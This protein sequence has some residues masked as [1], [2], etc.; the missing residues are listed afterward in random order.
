MKKIF[1]GCGSIF[2]VF[3]L[4]GACV[5]VIGGGSDDTNNT[6]SAHSGKEDQKSVA[7]IGDKVEADKLAYQVESVEEK[8]EL[9]NALGT[10]RPGSGKF[11][12]VEVTV[13]NN[14]TEGRAVTESMTKLVD[15]D[16]NEFESSPDAMMYLEGQADQS[17]L[18]D[19]INPKGKKT[20][21]MVY[22]ISG[23]ASDYK[24][25]GAGGL[26]FGSGSKVEI[27]LQK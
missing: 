6:P 12:I 9:R 25:V 17:A 21:K 18:F 3:L 1:I 27:L 10:K 11:L 13:W 4:L 15:K 24:F 2:A 23:K 19:K 7:K 5:A 22:D 16:G 14:D 20:Y 8:E 26:G